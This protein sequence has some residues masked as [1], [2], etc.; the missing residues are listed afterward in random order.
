MLASSISPE[1]L[2]P[3]LWRGSQFARGGPRTVDTGFASLSAELPGGGWPVGGL[4]ELLAAQPGCGEMRLLAPALAHTVSARRPL[5][6]VA[7]PQSPHASALAG[8]GVPADALLWLRA[9]SR[10]DALWAAEQALKTGCCGALLLWQD[11]RPEALRR[12]H[13]AAARTG[14]TLF[15]MLRPLQAARQPSPAVLRVALHPVPGG[16]SLD[17]VK[18]RGPAR[19][20]PLVLDL[21]SPIVESRYARLARHPSAAPAARRVR[22]A[23]V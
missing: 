14:D 11:A 8:L 6:L 10:T 23:A 15:V 20:E 22:P 9:G 1:S 17:I 18:R 7:P 2:H 3:S 4:V 16:V 13:L 21:P 19:G 5:A 12:L